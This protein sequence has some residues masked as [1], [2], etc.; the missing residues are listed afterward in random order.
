MASA[1]NP[2]M[3]VS[4]RHN[5]SVGKS[6]GRALKARKGVTTATTKGGIPDRDFYSFRCVYHIL[7][8]DVAK[9]L[10]GSDNFKPESIDPEKPGKIDVKRGKDSTTVTVER[11]SVQVKSNVAVLIIVLTCP[12]GR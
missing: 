9:W 1:E 11:A 7:V 6:L 5:V 12:L 8:L 10:H 2:W 4:G 3:P